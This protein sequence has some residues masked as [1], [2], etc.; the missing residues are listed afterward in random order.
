MKQFFLLLLPVIL[1]SNFLN[2]QSVGIG[3]TSPNASAM[4]DITSPS[5]NKGL[6]IPRMTALQR[7]TIASP[8]NGLMVYETTSNSLWIY[9]STSAT[10][11]QQS[12]GGISPW[13]TLN[14]QIYN[15]NT[16]RVGIGTSVPDTS[17]E[18]EI[19][20][21]NTGLLIP[22]MTSTQR[23]AIPLPARGLLVYETTTNSFWYFNSSVWNQIGTGGASPWTTSGTN[24]YNSNTGNV[25]IGTS[26]PTSK[27]HVAGNALFNGTNPILQ[28]QQ[29][30]VNAG[31]IQISGDDLRIGTNSGNS[32]GKMVVRMDG[33][34]RIFID[35]IGQV[36]I[37][38]ST[39]IYDLDINGNARI[40]STST[41]TKSVLNMY[42]NPYLSFD[43]TGFGSSYISFSNWT[44]L[45]GGNYDFNSK[46]K[47]EFD[48]GAA[49]RL[50]FQHVDYDYQLVLTKTG[51][52]GIGE[53]APAE[54]LQVNGNQLL[55]AAHPILKL[56]TTS[57]AAAT[58]EADIEFNG[59]SSNLASIRYTNSSLVMTGRNGA[60]NDLVLNNGNVGI[61]I[62]TP[63]EKLQLV[64]GNMLM[65]SSN[66]MIQMQQGSIDK[67]FIQL[68]GDDFR[69]GC[70][71]SNIN[72]KFVVRTAAGDQFFVD[73]AGYVGI[74]VT[75]LGAEAKVHVG[76][77]LGVSLTQNGYLMLGNSSGSNMVFDINEIQTR[78]NGAAASMILQRSGGTV[79][80]GGTAVPSG[81]KFAVDG[82]VICE[83]LKVKLV[84]SGWP[85]YV[86]G[87]NYTLPT[88]KEVEKYIQQNKHLPNIPSATEI[89]K[90]GIEVG[91]MQKRMMEK[92]EQMTLYIL[93]LQKQIDELKNK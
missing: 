17:A 78:T 32:A 47:I 20:S 42:A 56:K 59:P 49:E 62:G 84:S 93:Q 73:N 1:A 76:T 57:L 9:N 35:S 27:L 38:R 58:A 18:L 26:S 48:G 82:K 39:P 34:D 51:R 55:E 85:D 79:R 4:L 31:Y 70:N 77:G 54:K 52:V 21:T 6:L 81:Y 53:A 65:T 50:K 90:N 60:F 37:G 29:A 43:A 3:T 13:T 67:G 44:S 10:W 5:N 25:G 66:P 86:F 91:D 64:G 80:I 40:H 63:T 71:S 92:I 33:T 83:E 30:G 75:G 41:S 61:G 36:G 8:A 24:I 69:I 28:L 72:G 16:G 22:R 2:A 23:L 15:T 7:T 12:S 88:L 87:D 68:N 46:F 45:G 14:N 11:V 74:G 89:E 19:R